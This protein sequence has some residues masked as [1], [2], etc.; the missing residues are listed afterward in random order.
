MSKNLYDLFSE[1]RGELPEIKEEK[2]DSERIKQLV[3]QQTSEKKN[4]KVRRNP[5]MF[6]ISI[7]AALTAVT[8]IT[9]AAYSDNFGGFKKVL[10]RTEASPAVN[11]ELPLVN[12][13]DTD[14]MEDNIS[15]DSVAFTGS[16]SVSV[17]TA[18]MYYDNNTFMLSVE[19]KVSDG[20]SIRDDAVV[21]P[22]FT[23]YNGDTAVEMRD[24]SGAAN[25]AKLVK[26]DDAQ[27]YYATF[28]ITEKD[29]A[30]STIGV[31]L[32]NIIPRAALTDCQTA[33][34]AEQNKWHEEFG[35]DRSIE[36][37]KAYWKENDLDKRTLDFMD[38]YYRDC[39][40]IVEGSWT[41][42]VEVP[43]D[44]ADTST[45]ENNGF[46]V[47]ADT[48]SVTVDAE[49][50]IPEGAAYEP[51]ITLKNGDVIFTAGTNETEWFRENG[52][53]TS[54]DKHENFASVYSN[55]FSYSKPHDVDDIAEVAVY[56]F[57]YEDSEL[58]VEKNLVYTAD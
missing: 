33:I 52:V 30:G 31:R 8:S 27:T 10:R 53:F 45:F 2:C 50:D 12:G 51:V 1:Y 54:D 49:R 40:K 58:N 16:D 17:K 5:K 26:G 3:R 35:T 23:K 7:A 41:A 4:I 57:N 15:V 22:Y 29:I 56:I 46:R 47:K 37:W 44:I 20:I 21:I 18:G 25:A 34:V 39:D 13:S 43:A 9:A 11:S 28:Y 32:E 14:G 6:I 42:E 24:Q 36:D 48:L 55:V 38:S 19:M